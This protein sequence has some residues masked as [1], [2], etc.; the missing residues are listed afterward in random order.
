MSN[1]A[2]H[3]RLVTDADT[4][5]PAPVDLDVTNRD[6]AIAAIRTALKARSGKAWS[7]RGGTGTAWGWITISAPP[8]RIVDY[9]MTA[10]DTAE[11][12]ALLG[13]AWNP[14][15]G[16]ECGQS[17]SVPASAAHRREYVARAQGRPYTAAAPYWD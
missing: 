14:N 15:P 7:V 5:A 12:Y 2:R 16:C 11:L 4:P 10:E 8:K 17:I 1:A 6:V 9:R 3:L 13:I